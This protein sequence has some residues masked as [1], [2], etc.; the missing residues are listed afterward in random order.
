M[1]LDQPSQSQDLLTGLLIGALEAMPRTT[2]VRQRLL[3]D[4]LARL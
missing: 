2:E 4:C 3:A 1:A